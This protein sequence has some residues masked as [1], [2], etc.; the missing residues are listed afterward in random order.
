MAMNEGLKKRFVILVIIIKHAAFS[1]QK[2]IETRN[3]NW[4]HT[5]I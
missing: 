4:H 1:L 3:V 2:T 5:D